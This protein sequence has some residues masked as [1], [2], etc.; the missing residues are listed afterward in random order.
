MNE[1]RFNAIQC[2]SEDKAYRCPPLAGVRDGDSEQVAVRKLGPGEQKLQDLNKSI[3]YTELG[4]RLYLEKEQVYLMQ[5]AYKTIIG[6]LV[7]DR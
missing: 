3:F 2:Y 6:L 5:V 4:V 1:P 7:P